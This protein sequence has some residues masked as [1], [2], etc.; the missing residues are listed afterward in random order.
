MLLSYDLWHKCAKFISF[1]F[2][3]SCHS[4]KFYFY[5]KNAAVFLKKRKNFQSYQTLERPRL[6]LQNELSWCYPLPHGSRLARRSFWGGWRLIA[7]VVLKTVIIPS[8]LVSSF[9]F[10]VKNNSDTGIET[11]GTHGGRL[12]CDNKLRVTHLLLPRQ[13]LTSSSS[14]WTGTRT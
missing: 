13:M 5:T 14:P 6:G 7:E 4:C 12:G 2:L 11:L 8:D 10:H 3:I 1:I 9:L